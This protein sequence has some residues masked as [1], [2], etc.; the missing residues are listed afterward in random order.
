[1]TTRTAPVARTL[2]RRIG[3]LLIFGVLVL[4]SWEAFKLLAGDPWFID[5]VKAWDPPLR[6]WL[7][8]DVNLPHPWI[9]WTRSLAPLTSGASESLGGYL[10]G[11]AV[12][13]MRE[14]LTGFVIGGILGIG[15]ATLFVHFRLIERAFVPYVVASQTVPIIALAPLIM[16]F[17]GHNVS[18]VIIIAT[19]L[20]FFPVTIA[21]LRGLRS[22]DPRALELMRSYAASRRAV[23]WKVR[24]PA[25]LPYLFTA[26]KITA[27]ASVVG[28]IVGE[29][30]GGMQAGLGRAL[31][32]FSQQYA[33]SPEKLWASIFVTAALGI[34]FYLAI[35][36]AEMLVLRGRTGVVAA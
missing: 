35:V 8:S 10:I 3:A 9:I 16:F 2:R 19:Y 18:S 1:M 33:I 30:P 26:L 24:F 4:A 21:M 14:A 12:F 36:G 15:L 5:G 23:L 25:S 29:G 17:T 34:L 7:A 32:F 20:S 6:V 11:Q 28:A 13:T 22:P 27:T 31:M